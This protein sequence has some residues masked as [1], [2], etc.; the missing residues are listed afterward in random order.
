M[1]RFTRPERVRH[2]KDKYYS[3]TSK[4]FVICLFAAIFIALLALAAWGFSSGN[5]LVGIVAAI[6]VVVEFII[7]MFFIDLIWHEGE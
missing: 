4:A 1:S 6:L 5:W 7:G 3:K 2:L